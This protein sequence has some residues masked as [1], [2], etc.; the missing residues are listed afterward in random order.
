MINATRARELT[1]QAIELEIIT[2][3]ERAES[4]CEAVARDIEILCSEGK[5][6]MSVPA[7]PTGLISYVF[8][9]FKD[10]GF[11]VTQLNHNTIHI[12]W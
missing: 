8:G 6:E 9:I 3:K 10:N 5:K 2:R 11:T 1:E 12:C 4:F 7:I